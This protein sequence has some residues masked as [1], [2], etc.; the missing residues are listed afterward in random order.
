MG[1]PA[2]AQALDPQAA[3]RDY[4]RYAATYDWLDGGNTGNNKDDSL[5]VAS[6]L[7][8]PQARADL[9]GQARGHVLELG[10]GTGLNLPYYNWTQLESLTLLDVS[11]G[12]LHQ[13]QDK[14]QALQAS[15][16]QQQP[17]PPIRWVQG[18]ATSELVS[19]FGTNVF[20]TVVDTFSLCVMGTA[21][22]QECLTQQVSRVV[23]HTSPT[24][25]SGRVLLL[26]NTRASVPW[27]AW[28]QDVTAS[29]AARMGGKGCVYNQ[30]V[31]RLLQSPTRTT[32]LPTVDDHDTVRLQI[33]SQ[34][35]YAA[36][37]FRAFVLEPVSL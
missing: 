14:W 2:M 29:T 25:K 4:N 23:K 20:D 26:E 35:D 22:A 13:A 36:G 16:S 17:L 5:G 28:Y 15:H 37:L 7:G 19:L 12:M 11:P 3:A 21:G 27:L 1:G 32:P 18:D 24:T 6:W 33:V 34:T 10:V 9:I 30:Q 8:L 31:E